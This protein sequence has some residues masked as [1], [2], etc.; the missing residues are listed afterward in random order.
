M[1]TVNIR[2]R[3]T[4]L[5][6]RGSDLAAGYDLRANHDIDIPSGYGTFVG[7]GVYISMPDDM[8]C[9]IRPRSGLSTRHH[10]VIPNAPGT[11]DADYRG[12]IKVYLLNLGEDVFEVRKGDRIAQMVFSK[13]EVVQFEE[14]E[15]LDDTQRGSGGFGSTG[16]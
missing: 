4:V 10:V 14:V 9:E 8:Q 16:V 15:N 5:P 3:D 7:T 12:E 11:I 1:S 13:Y 2:L 6:V